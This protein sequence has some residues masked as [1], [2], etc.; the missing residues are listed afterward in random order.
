MST[1]VVDVK[2]VLQVNRQLQMQHPV[3]TQLC[4]MFQPLW[5]S[6]SKIYN[7]WNK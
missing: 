7:G 2:Q 5:P 4:H 1:F 3:L 6:S